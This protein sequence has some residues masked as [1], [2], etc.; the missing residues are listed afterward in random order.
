MKPIVLNNLTYGMYAIGVKND[1][2]AS[3]CIITTAMQV[4]NTKPPLVA[5]SVNRSNYSYKC[6]EKH[7]LFT[8][9]VLSEETP[10]TVIGALGFTSG[11]KSNKLE[12]IR[13]KVLIEGVPVLKENTCCWFLCKVISKTETNTQALYI[14][15]ITAGSDE[16]MGK[17]MTYEFYRNQLKGTSPKK[18]PTYLPPAATFDKASGESFACSVCGY[19][20]R[21]PSFSFEELPKD[22]LC[23]VCKMPKRVFIRR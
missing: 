19:V 7:G 18:A 10:A 21:D 15:E 2:R 22:W 5:V 23:P 3:A 17:P 4:A 9:S 16:S 12:N 14:A 6:I 8:L 11:E 1:K 20:Y 13:H